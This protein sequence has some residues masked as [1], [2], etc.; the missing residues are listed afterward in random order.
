MNASELVGSRTVS[1]GFK[2]RIHDV[3]GS[4]NTPFW[5]PANNTTLS[6]LPWGLNRYTAEPDF[7]LIVLNLSSA[8][9]VNNIAGVEGGWKY[10]VHLNA[11]LNNLLVPRGAFLSSPLG[12]ALL[13]DTNESVS[14]SG[15]GVTFHPKDWSARSDS[16]TNTPGNSTYIWV[17]S[18]TAQSQNNSPYGYYGGL[19]S[20]PS[21]EAGYESL[22]VQSVLWIN[23]SSSG[24]AGLGSENAELKDLFGGL[25]LNSS[26]NLSGNLLTVTSEL[27]TLGLPSNVLTALANVTIRNDGA[28]SPPKYQ[29]QQQPSPSWWEQVDA[30]VGNTLS[31]I[32]EVTGITKVVSVVW[33][34]VQAAEAYLGEAATVLS[35]D[36]GLDKLANQFVSGLK[37]LA[38]AM[39]W[40]FDQLL[41]AIKALIANLLGPP[42]RIIQRAFATLGEDAYEGFATANSTGN[43]GNPTATALFLDGIAPLFLTMATIAT[44]VAIAVGI[45]LPVDSI[46]GAIAVFLP[47]IVVAALGSSAQLTPVKA[48]S[49][50]F[51]S[52]STMLQSAASAASSFLDAG[53][54]GTNTASQTALLATL[55]S[56]AAVIVA[57]LVM[58]GG[59]A[60]AAASFA[61]AASLVAMIFLVEAADPLPGT[62]TQQVQNYLAMGTNLCTPIARG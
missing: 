16:A 33:N 29:P 44:L 4:A 21:V 60:P 18:T 51:D 56:A 27:G 24:Y 13:N 62:T 23:V 57:G 61:L 25:V 31:G 8:N 38:S 54:V 48:P 58:I 59:F 6:S 37:T 47:L 28:F 35:T 22:Q 41:N 55:L 46:L 53:C 14:R 34:A 12:Q 40:A 5:A 10:S 52:P 19:P 15:S 50:S 2:S 49:I 20:N 43:P 3:V 26:S 17:F 32:A 11:G 45:A 1:F 9:T 42:I 39:E 30:A 36:L 7:D